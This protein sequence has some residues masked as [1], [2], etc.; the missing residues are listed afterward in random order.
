MKINRYQLNPLNSLSSLI[1][2]YAVIDTCH[3]PV[4]VVNLQNYTN[5]EKQKFKLIL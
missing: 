3:Y 2:P 5:T 4:Y 1:S